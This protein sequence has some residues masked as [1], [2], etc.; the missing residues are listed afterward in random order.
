GFRIVLESRLQGFGCLV[1]DLDARLERWSASRVRTAKRNAET[2]IDRQIPAA[3]FSF[4]DRP[5]LQGHGIGLELVLVEAEFGADADLEGQAPFFRQPEPRTDAGAGELE[6]DARNMRRDQIPA[7][8]KVFG[9]AV[10]DLDGEVK[11][12]MVGEL[13]GRRILRPARIE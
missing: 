7:N 12:M 13:A 5:D 3:P 11:L 6:P 9:E 10:G 4:E 1:T 2:R 8:L